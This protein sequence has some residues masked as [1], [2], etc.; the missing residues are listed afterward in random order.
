MSE[1]GEQDSV[2][3]SVVVPFFDEQEAVEPFFVELCAVLDSLGDSAEIIAVDDGSGTQPLTAF[4]GSLTPTLGFASCGFGA[5]LA[6]RPRLPQALL[7]QGAESSSPWTGTC[8]MIPP[9]YQGFFGWF[10]RGTMWSRVGVEIA[11]T[12]P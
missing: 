2:D 9:T 7:W 11:R 3:L 4:E 6:R 8:R 5:T 10:Q 12:T 1:E